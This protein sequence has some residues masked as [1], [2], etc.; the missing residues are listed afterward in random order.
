MIAVARAGIPCLVL[1]LA[2]AARAAPA[3]TTA[4]VPPPD[5]ATLNKLSA[6]LAPVDL[7]VDVQALPASERAAL[8][9]LIAAAKIMDALFL[10]QV[11]AGNERCCSIWCAIDR[12]SGQARLHA[13]L[14]NKGPWL[15][16]DGDRPFLPRRRS[17]AAARP[18]SIPRTRPRPRSRPGCTR[19]PRRRARPPRASSRRSAA[20]PTASCRRSRTASNTRASSSAPPRA[21]RDAAALTQQPTLRA[22]LEAR[23]AAFLSNDYYDSDVAWMK[24]DASIE[25]TIGPY[26]TYEDGWFSA[27]A[28]FE[29]FISVRDDA[30][31]AKL[32]KLGRRAAG[33]RE[34]PAD[35]RRSC[36]TR[37]WARLAPIRVVN[38]LF[39]AGDANKAVQTAAFNLPNDERIIKQV[40][41][42][43]MMLKNVQHAKFDKVLLPIS[44][45]A[46]APARSTARVVRRVLHAHPDARA[47]ARPRPARDD[48][49]RAASRR[50]SGPRC[51]RATARS[52]KRRP[53]SRAS[54]RCST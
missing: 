7:T 1:V 10:R 48:R 43:R 53:T 13:F 2:A 45:I 40:G 30:E 50:R 20:R 51:S 39:A 21:L 31:T 35:R 34:Q 44:R 9:E 38:Q 15:R 4:A 3:P 16:L 27:K 28:A 18:T 6:R 19:C 12:R 42:K 46:L 32:A 24:L 11:W 52:R 26:E 5:A 54:S 36:A 49:R 29:A 8:V 37:S 22:F 14:Q 23:A 47:D 41:S 25:P 33:D 17:E